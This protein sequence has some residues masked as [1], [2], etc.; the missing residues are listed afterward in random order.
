[1]VT[2]DKGAEREANLDLTPA[3]TMT[4]SFTFEVQ[5]NLIYDLF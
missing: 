4:G 5:W 2:R 3:A 1:M